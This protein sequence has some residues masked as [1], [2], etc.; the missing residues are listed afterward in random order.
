M[1]GKQRRACSTS[2]RSPCSAKRVELVQPH[3]HPREVSPLQA[4]LVTIPPHHAPREHRPIDARRPRARRAARL[5]SQR[6]RRV[7]RPVRAV[8]RRSVSTFSVRGGR[9]KQ[10]ERAAA[11]A[12]VAMAL[13]GS[14]QPQPQARVR[15]LRLGGT[16]CSVVESGQARARSC[17]TLRPSLGAGAARAEKVAGARPFPLP[18]PRAHQEGK[19]ALHLRP[20]DPRAPHRPLIRF[21]HLP[22]PSYS[23]AKKWGLGAVVVADAV[24]EKSRRRCRWPRDGHP[25]GV[26]WVERD[27]RQQGNEAWLMGLSTLLR[28]LGT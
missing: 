26:P 13:C 1:P 24:K 12:A 11:A 16:R 9:R 8:P 23:M 17:E 5:Q 4:H 27:L 7:V 25:R 28:R 21:L 22:G 3:A 19:G 18:P 20:P 6:Q 15:T 14:A 2:M 10:P